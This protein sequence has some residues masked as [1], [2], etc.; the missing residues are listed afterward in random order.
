MKNS[1]ISIIVLFV[2]LFFFFFF[3]FFFFWFD[4]LKN[5]IQNV[6]REKNGKLFTVI[7]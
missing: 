7:N 3:F 5:L 1:V 4:F 2:L 6:S